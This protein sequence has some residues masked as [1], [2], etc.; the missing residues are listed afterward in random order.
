MGDGEKYS[1]SEEAA[2][3]E[4]DYKRPD[5][6]LRPATNVQWDFPHITWTDSLDENK[7]S[8]YIADFFFSETADGEPRWISGGFNARRGLREEIIQKYGEG[9]YYA[10]T[11]G[12]SADIMQYQNSPLSQ[13]SPAYHLTAASTKD[14]LKEILDSAEENTPEDVRSAV[15]DLD[16]NELKTALLADQNEPGGTADLLGQL[17]GK[18]G[19]TVS[20]AAQ[21]PEFESMAG[22]ANIVGAALNDVPEGTNTITLNI[23]S[24]E[25]EHVIPEQYHNAVAL[26]FSMGLD[27]V[28]DQGNLKVPVRVTLPIPS[29]INPRF[30]VLLHYGQNGSVEEITGDKTYVYQKEDGWYVSFV[31]THFSDFVMTE[32]KQAEPE[33]TPTPVPPSSGGISWDDDNDDDDDDRPSKP[34]KAPA[35]TVTP[36]PTVSPAPTASPVPTETP[37]PTPIP[38]TGS[39]ADIKAADWYVDAVQYVCDKGMMNGV[40]ENTFSPNTP[41]NRG[42]LVTILYR[43]EGEPDASAAGFSDVDGGQYY[44]KAV[45]WASQNGL[46]NGFED[47]TFRPDEPVTREQIATILYRYAAFQGRDVTAKADLSGFSDEAQVG[48]YAREPM[49]WAKA[50]GL[51]TGTDWNGL[52][53]GGYATR[54]ETAAILMRFC[55]K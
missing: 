43:L 29:N 41:T 44:A 16:T 13:L 51:I 32:Q 54:A 40:T 53:P 39:F 18:M 9:Y 3:E 46:V 28:T 45:A 50:E 48:G 55:E 26:Q 23:G 22:N 47:G 20:T 4:I 33:P 52:H 27:G 38:V 42:M 37:A 25:E 5:T 7:I 2:S 35:P 6:V 36:T 14:S 17:E 34:S 11:Y 10:A 30:L 31:L 12:I 49:A 1:D 24:P 15:Q 8:F 19:I 21:K